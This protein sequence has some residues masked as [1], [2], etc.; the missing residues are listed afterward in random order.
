MKKNSLQKKKK[1]NKT[2]IETSN[3]KQPKTHVLKE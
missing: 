1:K 2:I 3:G